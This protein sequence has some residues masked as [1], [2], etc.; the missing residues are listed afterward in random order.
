[1]VVVRGRLT[2]E[3]GA[4]LRRALDAACDAAGRAPEPDGGEEAAVA[5]EEAAAVEAAAGGGAQ[6]TL[7]QRQADAIGVVV[8]AALAGGLDKGTAGDRYQVVLHVDAAA[9]AEP[10]ERD[11]PAGTSVGS[12]AGS[13]PG[14]HGGDVPAGTLAGAV[15]ATG[16]HGCGGDVPAG[17][18]GDDGRGVGR[19]RQRVAARRRRSLPRGTQPAPALAP[20]ARSVSGC[21]PRAITRRGTDRARRRDGTGRAVR[22]QPD[23]A[24]PGGRHPRLRGDRPAR[25]VRRRHR[26]DAPR[27]RR[28]DPRRRPPHA[29]HLPG[30][31]PGAG[32]PRPAV[33]LPPAAATAGRTPITSSTGPTA[34]GRRST[35]WCCSA[36]T[37]ARCTRGAFASRST[38]P[39]TCASCGRTVGRWQRFRRRT[40]G[41][42]RRSARRTTVWRRRGSRSTRGRRR[43]PGRGSGWTSTG[44][45]ACCGAR[46]ARG[47]GT[48]PRVGHG[49]G[50]STD[51]RDAPPRGPGGSSLPEVPE[52]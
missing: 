25:R 32:G 15:S 16:P 18:A 39:G 19:S 48:E 40:P 30:P 47:P 37:T 42:G 20:D 51:L 35:T 33:P 23:R 31:P 29:N 17:N 52:R 9:L 21:A 27:A 24:R 36:A 10:R 38:P 3:V 49:R 12:E 50:C 14:A 26:H 41:P 22:G 6:P 13:E 2:P 44:R 5:S 8:E 45:S 11:V 1:M 28:R 46:G 34:A 7:A 4:V 43:R